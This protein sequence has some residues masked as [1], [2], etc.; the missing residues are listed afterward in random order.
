[1]T[2]ARKD[3]LSVLRFLD[4]DSHEKKMDVL[5]ALLQAGENESRV[6]FSEILKRLQSDDTEK[7]NKSLIYRLLSSLE[8]DGFIE[9]DRSGYRHRYSSDLERIE[10][11]LQKKRERTLDEL[12]EREVKLERQLE[13]L[14]NMD[15]GLL[16]DRLIKAITDAKW[17][18]RSRFGMGLRSLQLMADREAYAQAVKGDTIRITVDD[19]DLLSDKWNKRLEG[20][21]NLAS[22]GVRVRAL[23]TEAC[24]QVKDKWRD[25]KEEYISFKSEGLDVDFRIRTGDLT[26]QIVARNTDVL[27]L[28]VAEE[29]L[30]SICVPRNE[31]PSLLDDVMDSFDAEFLSS[32][33]LLECVA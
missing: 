18:D 32:V 9:V 29:P 21:G 12:S 23:F 19:V 31:N 27:V 8:A 10:K 26:Y 3:E 13:R 25:T 24:K 22:R 16:V 7:P 2:A 14:R 1:M 11:T 17:T 6:G 33:N 30:A 28:T 4:V 20:L 15:I 5:R